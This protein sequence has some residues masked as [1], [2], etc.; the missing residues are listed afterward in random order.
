MD[1][2]LEI[3]S[4]KAQDYSS[5]QNISID[6]NQQ[7]IVEPLVESAQN[8]SQTRHTRLAA[9]GDKEN[10]PWAVQ[11][12]EDRHLYSSDSDEE[13]AHSTSSYKKILLRDQ[14]ANRLIERFVKEPSGLKESKVRAIDFSIEACFERLSSIGYRVMMVNYMTYEV[15]EITVKV[16]QFRGG[17]TSRYLSDLN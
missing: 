6:M 11:G 1:F 10:Q 16:N 12:T 15:E 17:V 5:L 14:N 8:T 4:E 7:A 13:N 2:S 3:P 9:K